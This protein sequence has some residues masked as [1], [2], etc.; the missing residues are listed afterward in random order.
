[1]GSPIFVQFRSYG[2]RF[3]NERASQ[4]G[5]WLLMAPGLLLTLM[6]LS[7]L[8]WPHLLAYMI[9]T[10]MLFGGVSLLVWGWSMRQIG[11]RSQNNG[12]VYYREE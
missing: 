12:T 5:G 8:L 7:I 11:R 4:S 9:A 10:V 2:Q 3:A 1:M 6:A